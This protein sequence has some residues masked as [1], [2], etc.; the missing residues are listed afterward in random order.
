LAV[1]G[2]ER[3]RAGAVMP[4]IALAASPSLLDRVGTMALG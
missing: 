4:R 3:A 1:L 2:P